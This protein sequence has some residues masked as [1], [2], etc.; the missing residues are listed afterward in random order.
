MCQFC[1]LP[2][3]ELDKLDV[4]M[5][6][7]FYREESPTRSFPAVQILAKRLG[8]A[9]NTVRARSEKLTASL[10]SGWSLMVNPS[11]LGE[12][13]GKLTFDPWDRPKGRSIGQAKAS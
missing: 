8:V 9:E 1:T 5:I 10:L 7:E 3:A 12:K 13:A 6:R 4:R 11:L 2:L